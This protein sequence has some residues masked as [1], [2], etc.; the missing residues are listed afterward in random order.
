DGPR[1]TPLPL[2]IAASPATDEVRRLQ[3]DLAGAQA[4]VAALSAD[5][6]AA[7]GSGVGTA[8]DAA[9]DLAALKEQ[10][11]AAHRLAERLGA[12]L[13]GEPA[14]ERSESAGDAA[15]LPSPPAP[16]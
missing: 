5:L 15:P 16:R 12:T 7:K 6:E 4:T 2:A 8:S 13:T 1:A 9:A 10:L 3:Q 14:Q 11:G